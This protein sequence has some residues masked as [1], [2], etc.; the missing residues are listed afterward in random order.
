M[1]R[2]RKSELYSEM[3]SDHSPVL[4]F[5]KVEFEGTVDWATMDTEKSKNREKNSDGSIGVED[6]ICLSVYVAP[7]WTLYKSIQTPRPL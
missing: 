1:S 4:T 3:A 2:A 5:L 6:S 7:K